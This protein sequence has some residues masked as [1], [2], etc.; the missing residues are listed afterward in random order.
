MRLLPR[1][2]RLLCEQPGPSERRRLRGRRPGA[3]AQ[4]QASVA[5]VT[6]VEQIHHD[7]G[8]QQRRRV[9]DARR[10][11]ATDT[12]TSQH[13]ETR[14]RKRHAAGASMMVGGP[15]AWAAGRRC[16]TQRA[17]GAGRTTQRGGPTSVGSK[18]A[19]QKTRAHTAQTTLRGAGGRSATGARSRQP[20]EGKGGLLPAPRA[21]ASVSW[22]HAMMLPMEHAGVKR[23]QA[24]QRSDAR[25]RQ[26]R[27]IGHRVATTKRG[28]PRPITSVTAM[29]YCH[30]HPRHSITMPRG[31]AA[32][33]SEKHTRTYGAVSQAEASDQRGG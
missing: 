19:S 25:W 11:H 28:R 26:V 4:G 7:A 13:R 6:A 12:R 32:W 27:C 33:D 8:L 16:T 21:G 22:R 1:S 14:T 9:S 20:G 31:E 18:R 15:R 10:P 2:N 3:G 24:A 17:R 23:T 5:C 30:T 29:G